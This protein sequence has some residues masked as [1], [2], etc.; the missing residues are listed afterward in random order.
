MDLRKFYF[1][2]INADE[3][4]YKFKD[5]IKNVNKKYIVVGRYQNVIE[6]DL[7]FEIYD[8][9]EAISRFKALCQPTEEFNDNEKKCWFYLITYY[10][11]KLGFQIKEFPKVLARPPINPIEFTY[12]D[13]RNKI[14][15]QGDDNNGNIP[16]TKR[17]LFVANL[18]F[19]LGPNNI[20]IPDTIDKRFRKISNR[21]AEFKNMST[22]EKLAE[23]VNLIENLLKKDGKFFSVDYS[24]VCFEH[25]NEPTIKTYKN[26]IQCFRH[27]SPESMA[28]REEFSSEQKSFLVDYGLIIIKATYDILK[29]TNEAIL[30]DNI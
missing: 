12:T 20:E 14:T 8:V 27:A 15:A 19:E 30:Y 22:D 10:L 25:I 3:Y 17:S 6:T 11:H 26:K 7:K 1:E 18:T 2:N 4:H 13:V 28:E 16:F 24:P 23:I 21:N 29:M 5:Q 9:E